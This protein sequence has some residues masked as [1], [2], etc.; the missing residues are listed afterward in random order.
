MQDRHQS[1][2]TICMFGGV[3]HGKTTLATAMLKV[4]QHIGATEIKDTQFQ[5]IDPVSYRITEQLSTLFR[6]VKF[7]TSGKHYRLIDSESHADLIKAIIGSSPEIQ[8]AILVVRTTDGV[9]KEIIEQIQLANQIGIRTVF[10]FLNKVNMTEDPELIGMCQD[11]TEELLTE[12][13]YTGEKKPLTIIGDIDSALKYKGKDLGAADWQPI[14]DLIFSLAQHT[15]NPVLSNELPLIVPISKILEEKKGVTT[16]QGE[17]LRGQLAIG[18]NVDIVGKGDR[19]QTRCVGYN[20]TRIQIDAEPGWVTTGQI[21]SSPKQIRSYNQFKAAIY[22]MTV[23]ESGIHMPIVGNDKPDIH[24]WTIDVSG[25]ITLPPGIPIVNPGEHAIVLVEL[26]I[27]MAMQV[28]T[29]FE[30]KKTNQL[31]G[32]GIVTEIVQ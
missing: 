4:V 1:Y 12:Y 11:E 28:C 9:T 5:Q 2:P 21:V 10:A 29:R 23:E 27:P 24:L 31:I 19:I 16:I 14:V 32:I 3:K 15:L 8:A 26:E 7:E 6:T 20:Q 30:I 18:Q 13:G 22:L 17:K 25:H